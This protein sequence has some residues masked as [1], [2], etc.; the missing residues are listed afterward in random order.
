LMI[1][2]L[3]ETVWSSNRCLLE[4][5]HPNSC[6]DLPD[7]RYP[8]TV[9]GGSCE[10]FLQCSNK[11]VVDKRACWLS[12]VFNPLIQKCD[13][14]A[15][16]SSDLYLFDSCPLLNVG[17]SPACFNKSDGFYADQLG[18]CNMYYQ[19]TNRN[20]LKWF[21]C[22]A[23][24]IFN[25][26]T[27]RCDDGRTVPRDLHPRCGQGPSCRGRK[28]GLYPDQA[29]LC[30][31]FFACR[32]E[33]FQSYFTCKSTKL[34]FNPVTKRCQSR[35]LVPAEAYP[36]SMSYCT[37]GLPD[38]WGR[39]DGL[40]PDDEGRCNIFYEC[41]ASRFREWRLCPDR[42]SFNPVS[43]KCEDEYSIPKG[44]YVKAY[45]KIYSKIYSKGYSRPSSFS[46]A[47]AAAPAV[48]TLPKGATEKG[49]ATQRG[50]PA[51]AQMPNFVAPEEKSEGFKENSDPNNIN[52]ILPRDGNFRWA[53][54]AAKCE[55]APSC[56]GRVDGNY[57]HYKRNCEW[58]YTCHNQTFAGFSRCGGFMR[59]PVFNER[60]KRCD[61]PNEVLPPCGSFSEDHICATRLDG[62]YPAGQRG[63]TA[64]LVCAGGTFRGYETCPRNQVFNR[65]ILQCADRDKTPPPCGSEV[66]PYPQ[67]TN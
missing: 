47:G 7:G 60:T 20:F 51:G 32:S 37:S 1:E 15:N 39:P 10:C 5:V 23:N 44:A 52:R 21:R 40:Y 22:P 14:Y 25:P 55:T 56:L 3:D 17:H 13:Y 42:L 38:C 48:R 11:A 24:L 26:L 28:D 19:C 57:P 4:D 63:C 59:Q 43:Q 2:G 61:N 66:D 6:V 16:V 18:R 64:Y 54:A 62:L 46:A 29:G 67:R 49:A 50:A 53:A 65:H 8:L 12:Y 35:A 58:Y 31:R 27:S 9:F 41:K 34:V 45:S 33:T 36:P 30:H